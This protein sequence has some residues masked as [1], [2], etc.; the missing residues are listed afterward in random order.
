LPSLV[1]ELDH[2]EALGVEEINPADRFALAT[3]G[4][5]WPQTS[6]S[7]LMQAQ[8]QPRFPT[9]SLQPLAKR[10]ACRARQQLRWPAVRASQPDSSGAVVRPVANAASIVTTP[11]SMP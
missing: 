3:D 5:L 7:Q 11:C 9:D 8:P 1:V 2:D 6:M 4:Y 10:T